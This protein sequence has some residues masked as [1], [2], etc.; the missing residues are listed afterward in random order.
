MLIVLGNGEAYVV[1]SL[2]GDHW[3]LYLTGPLCHH[4]PMLFNPSN[5]QD[6]TLEILMTHLDPVNAEKFH[7]E[8]AKAE[9]HVHGSIIAEQCGLMDIFP[10][11]PH[12]G[13]RLDGY[14]FAPCGFSANAV[15]ATPQSRQFAKTE[16]PG[17][18]FTVHVTPEQGYSYASFE[19]N[20]PGD[21]FPGRATGQ[22]VS[23]VV[24]GFKPG[25]M[26]ITK[27]VS[28][29]NKSDSDGESDF[30][31]DSGFVD[32]FHAAKEN[33][34]DWKVEGYRR[35]EKIVYEFDGYDL[36]FASFI[37]TE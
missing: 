24:N 34:W 21:M 1:G 3:Y 31:R 30:G 36:I 27:F 4:S 28:H 9:G 14:A 19:T 33:K 22:V 18:Y 12:C 8:S 25:R 2:I 23:R 10:V 5:L 20:I 26:C 11:D 32:D 7:L 37:R 6:E 17:Y 15:I 29:R 13:G 35:C 16:T